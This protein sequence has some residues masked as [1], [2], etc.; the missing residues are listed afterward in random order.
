MTETPRKDAPRRALTPLGH[1]LRRRPGRVMSPSERD[2]VTRELFFEASDR[3]RYLTQFLLLTVL[4]TLIAVLGLV[5][6]SVAVVIGAMLI[7]PLMTPILATSA[8]LLLA[9]LRRLGTSIAVLVGGTIVAVLT[10]ALATWLGLQSITTATGL[11]SEILARTEPSLL[12]LGVAI[13]AGLAAGY[14]ITH[15]QANASLPGVAIAVALVPP[16]ATVGITWQLG[17]SEQAEGALLLYATNLVAI[18]LSAIIVMLASGF[19]P[20][21]IRPRALRSARIGLL[22]TFILLLAIAV[23]LTIFTVDRVQDQ[24]F[25]RSVVDEITRWD[26]NAT[27]VQLDADVE[28]DDRATVDLIVATTSVEA[29]PA[30]ELSDA[31]A[32]RTGMIVDLSVRYRLESQ[33]ASTSG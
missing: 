2:A 32:R 7:A 15:P 19:I 9:D 20:E 18:V 3:S 4:S 5:A 29:P 31:L 28:T 24:G 21:E 6:N 33:D 14:V 16:L 26:P 23:P 1:W 12:D 25:T 30:W 11:P 22:A 27:V 10:A 8:S 13:A 17:A